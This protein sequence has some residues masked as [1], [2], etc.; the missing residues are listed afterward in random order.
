ITALAHANP[1]RDGAGTLVG[2]VN[3]LVDISDRKRAEVILREADQAKNEF[4]AI[5]AH[6]L[7]NPLAPLVN[8]IEIL[9]LAG[10][11]PELRDRA[12]GTL[13]RQVAHLTR[14]V[15]D[16]IDVSR[17]T[18]GKLHLRLERVSLAA[19]VQCAVEASKPLLDARGH[20]F[21]EVLPEEPIY[22]DADLVRLAQVFTNL[23]NNAAKYSPP[24]SEITLTAVRDNAH[25][26]VRV[27]DSGSGMSRE[28]LARIFDLF[29]QADP[30]AEASHGGLGIGLAVS[31]RLVEMHE[32]TIAARSDGLG[33]GSEFTVRIPTTAYHARLR[34]L[35]RPS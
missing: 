31:K 34:E 6:E 12:R 33:Q 22:F 5:L 2:A 18:R 20:K 29:T 10:D 15:D 25:V 30:A 23:L 28:T 1:L 13:E 19:L 8:A 21:V 35:E 4:L 32:G 17:I 7:R 26:R 27:R 14:L 11:N 3:I 24:G 16:L 9:K